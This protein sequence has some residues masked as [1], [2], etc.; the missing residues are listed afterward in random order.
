MRLPNYSSIYSPG[1][2]LL[3]IPAL[4]RRIWKPVGRCEVMLL[5][6]PHPWALVLWC[7]GKLRRKRIA[8]VVRQDLQVIVTYRSPPD[9]R[10]FVLRGARLF[11]A[12]FVWLSRTHADLRCR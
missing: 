12:V 10:R 8:F 7:V 11:E 4:L 5:G 2:T 3:G 6:I 9:R 1:E